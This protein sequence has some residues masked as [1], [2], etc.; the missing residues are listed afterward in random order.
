MY[1]VLHTSTTAVSCGRMGT[2]GQGP[3]PKLYPLTSLSRVTVSAPSV[4]G[5]RVRLLSLSFVRIVRFACPY[6][7]QLYILYRITVYSVHDTV[8]LVS[9][10]E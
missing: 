10:K 2:G 7:L 5:R 8:G 3:V 9:G 6:T 4:P 1:S